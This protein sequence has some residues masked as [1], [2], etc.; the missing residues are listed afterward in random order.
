MKFL[1]LILSILISL[2]TISQINKKKPIRDSNK[3]GTLFISWGYNRCVYSESDLYLSG[4]GYNFDLDNAKATDN[5]SKLNSGDY[6]LKKLTVPQYNFKIGYYYKEKWSLSFAIDHMKYLFANN[7]QIAL[8]GFVCIP[9][10][11]VS[12]GEGES[13]GNTYHYSKYLTTNNNQFSFSNSKGLNYI[14]AELGC[15]EKLFV[16]GKKGNFVIS[17]NLGLGVGTLLSYTN[18]LFNGTRTE[19]IKSLSGYGVSGFAGLRFEIYK[20][21]YIYSNFSVGFLHKIYEKTSTI[22]QVANASQHF[23][24]SQIEVGLGV[25]LFKRFKNKCDDCPVW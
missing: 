5:Q 18:L 14:H 2:R 23:G 9:D 11:L 8:S 12:L 1:F 17:S 19:N 25:F 22:D 3:K 10:K 20:R 21:A 4:S 7:N 15:T 16:A 13:I 24:Y 6:T